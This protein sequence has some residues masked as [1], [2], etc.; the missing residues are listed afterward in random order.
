MFHYEIRRNFPSLDEV[1]YR[2][3]AKELRERPTP[4]HAAL[5]VFISNIGN[6]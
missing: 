5:L 1:N 4:Q 6:V 3:M 2:G